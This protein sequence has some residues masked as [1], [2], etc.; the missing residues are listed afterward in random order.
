MVTTREQEQDS[1]HAQTDVRVAV[2]VNLDAVLGTLHRDVQRITNLVAVGLQSPVVLDGESLAI[3]SEPIGFRFGN[4]SLWSS[5]DE[6]RA[7]Y[8]D[9]VFGNG[10]RDVIESVGGFLE[11]V[12]QV[13]A[14]WSLGDRQA[15]GEQLTGKALHE[16][17]TDAPKRFHRLGFPDKLNTLRNSFDVHVDPNLDDQVLSVNAARNC[18]VHRRGIVSERDLNGDGL[19]VVRWRRL[20]MFLQNEDGEYPV[21][22]GDPLEKAASVVV[23]TQDASKKF[24]LG[25]RVVFTSTEFAEICWSMFLYSFA[26]GEALNNFGLQ[27]GYISVPVVNIE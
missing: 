6:A 9:W 26:W 20:A 21:V 17:M 15:A 7:D 11:E 14:I 18:L 22:F 23:Q 3:R 27:R 16:E 5:R 19:L 13:V 1:A 12:R 25:E 10:F 4:S 8:E 2:N 24:R